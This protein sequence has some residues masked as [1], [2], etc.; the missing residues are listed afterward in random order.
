MP[1]NQ[2]KMLGNRSHYL[3]SW[4][5]GLDS[6]ALIYRLLIDGHQVSAVYTEIKN[7]KS[8]TQRELKAIKSLCKILNQYNFIY[9]GKNSIDLHVVNTTGLFLHQIPAWIH[10]L[11]YASPKEC[12]G[13]VCIGYVMNDD[14]ISFLDEIK[15]VWDSYRVIKSHL[16][17]LIFPLSK[18]KK[19]E[20]YQGLPE[21]IKKLITWCELDN[22][23]DCKCHSCI[24]M[25][26]ILPLKVPF[27]NYIE[28][29]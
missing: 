10:S 9:L 28:D 26:E 19:E 18:V 3:V 2:I 11:V 17:E 22:A 4:S 13:G 21:K 29:K 15:S 7:N 25:N 27:N 23:P 12:D 24:K 20:L 1:N 8:K 16:P 14:A 6:T 5:G